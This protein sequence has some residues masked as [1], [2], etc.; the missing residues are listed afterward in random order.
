MTL[1]ETGQ[2]CV[3]I[4]QICIISIPWT[5]GYN[6]NIETKEQGE[7][8]EQKKEITQETEHAA[9]DIGAADHHTFGLI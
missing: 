8:D 2:N 3:T 6:T 5:F 9:D 4:V 7:S 1:W